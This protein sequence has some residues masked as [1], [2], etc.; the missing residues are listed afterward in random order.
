M[1]LNLG[2]EEQEMGSILL[3]KAGGGGG[4]G[5]GGGGGGE[6]VRWRKMLR[7]RASERGGEGQSPLIMGGWKARGRQC[8]IMSL[9][10]VRT[11]HKKKKKIKRYAALKGEREK[12]TEGWRNQNL[13]A[14]APSPISSSWEEK[15]VAKKRAKDKKGH[16]RYRHTH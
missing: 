13:G 7:E 10:N 9:R 15:V 3:M 14:E 16:G 4:G 6:G 1:K 11:K 5:C 8:Q 12:I 2:R